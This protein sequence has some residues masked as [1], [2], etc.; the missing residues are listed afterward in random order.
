MLEL[1]TTPKVNEN[2]S[3]PIIHVVVKSTSTCTK[4]NKI[5]HILETCHNWKKEVVV[6]STATVK[7]IKHVTWS[8]AQ[9][10]K[11]TKIPPHPI[12]VLYV[13]V[14]IIDLEI[15]LGKLKYTICSEPNF[16]V[17]VQC[18]VSLLNW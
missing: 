5:G 13:L 9:P 18:H 11:P 6:V 4:C 8:N 2:M 15:V 12:L 14:P 3:N 7:S 10:I 16:L 1:L 17:L